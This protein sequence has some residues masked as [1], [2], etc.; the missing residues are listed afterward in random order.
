[1]VEAF[2]VQCQNPACPKSA[3]PVL[4][5]SNPEHV[6]GYTPSALPEGV[7]SRAWESEDPRNRAEDGF[8]LEWGLF[9]TACGD[10]M[11]RLD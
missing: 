6:Y 2:A 7:E 8:V 10:R 11:R 9:C 4:I 5:R 3:K 1:M